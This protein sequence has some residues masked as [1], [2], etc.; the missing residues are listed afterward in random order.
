MAVTRMALTP[1]EAC[2][3]QW[4]S[5]WR[6]PT[7]SAVQAQLN[8][9]RL[10]ALAVKNR[11]QTLLQ[12]VLVATGLQ[13]Q[14]PPTAAAALQEAAAKYQDN[15][16]RLGTTLRHYLHHAAAYNQEVVVLKGLWLSLKI[17]GH[18]A[19]RPGNDIDVLLRHKDIP[20]SLAILEEQMGYGR[21]WRPLLDDAYYDRHHLHQQRCNP[22]RSIWFEPHW[23]LDHPYTLLTIDYEALMDRTTPGELWG[24]PIREMSLPDLISSLVV[25]LVKHAVYLP[26]VINRPDLPQLI[27]ADGMMMYYVDVA[28]VIKLYETEIEWQTL[29]NL[30]H[31]GGL[32]AML[33]AVLRV[34]RDYL[35]T[36]VPDWVLA[37]LP[38]SQS[39][40][41]TR[42]VMNRLADYEIAT[43]QGQRPGRLWTFL[44]GYQDAIVFRPIRLLDLIQYLLPG[45]DYLQRR[46]GHS[47]VGTAVLHLLRATG[48]YVRVGVDTVYFTMQ[49]R[50]YLRE[51]DKQG[52]TQSQVSW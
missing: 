27:L 4:A 32:V 24:E 30:A 10:V 7:A 50:R 25:H 44:L 48:Q 31:Q 5:T 8:W 28:E 2:L 9:E 46:Y 52:G 41:V 22:N 43:Y 45:R 6:N 18:A 35:D 19:M 38:V 20:R 13:V 1:E 17:Y 29:I 40:V 11:M 12:Q 36:P 21:W 14:L 39:G 47:G 42:W 33:G 26:T 23:L 51:L 15:A 16:Q 37:A 49:R 3:W 34:C